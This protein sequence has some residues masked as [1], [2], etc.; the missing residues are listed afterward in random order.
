MKWMIGILF[1]LLV[2]ILVAIA[3]AVLLTALTLLF[4]TRQGSIPRGLP[5]NSL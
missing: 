5:R 1:I 3:Y 2:L 4:T